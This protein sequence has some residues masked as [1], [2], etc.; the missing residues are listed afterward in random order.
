[1]SQPMLKSKD[2]GFI[3]TSKEYAFDEFVQKTFSTIT[4]LEASSKDFKDF[5]DLNSPTI[6]LVI[7][8][9]RSIF[10]DKKLL[11]ADVGVYMGYFTIAASL[12]AS[13]ASESH[14]IYAFEANPKLIDPIR[15]NIEFYGIGKNASVVNFALGDKRG[16]IEFTMQKH[17][18]I[19]GTVFNT[20]AK[21]KGGEH[22]SYL[23][24]CLT[25]RDM[26]NDYLGGNAIIKLD[27]EGNEASAFSTI[28]NT[29]LAQ[30]NIFIIEY[31]HWQDN[32]E[33]GENIRYVDFL[34]E[35]FYIYRLGSWVNAKSFERIELGDANMIENGNRAF[36]VDLLLIP[37]QFNY[38]SNNLSIYL[39]KS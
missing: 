39:P 25:L 22:E 13:S 16:L 10:P 7:N 35:N 17:R 31:S 21:K 4:E 14:H 23:V 1:M 18:A 3:T 6:G 34:S 15:Q 2:T 29:N 38:D 28:I 37:K 8:L 27:I 30:E 12:K 9:F 5:L 32:L 19:G 11:F 33:V 26:C 24:P 20:E 36:N